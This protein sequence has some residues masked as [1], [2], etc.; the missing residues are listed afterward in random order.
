V[1]PV[2]VA[3][4]VGVVLERLDLPGDAPLRQAPLGASDEVFD[5]PFA[6]PVG[7]HQVAEVVALGCRVFRMEPGVHVEPGPVLKKHV[8][9]HRE[10]RDVLEKIP[11][12]HVG[13]Q[14]D[15]PL[16]GARQSVLAFQAEDAA[17]H[18]AVDRSKWRAP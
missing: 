9:H 15:A 16:L 4:V 10:G 6:R 2:G 11:C 18:H 17:L 1:A 14:D 12:E 13:A 8:R 5:D 3:G 7:A